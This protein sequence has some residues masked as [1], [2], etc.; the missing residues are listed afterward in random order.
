MNMGMD[1]A[2]TATHAGARRAEEKICDTVAPA[3]AYERRNDANA[4]L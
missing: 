1:A 3:D 2:S 4:L